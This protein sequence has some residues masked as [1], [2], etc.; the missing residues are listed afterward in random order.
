MSKAR[1]E[2]SPP[3]LSLSTYPL[4]VHSFLPIKPPLLKD[5]LSLS[6]HTNY[7]CIHFCQKTTTFDIFSL[8]LSQ[9]PLLVHSFLPIKPPLLIDFFSLST[10]LTVAFFFANKTTSFE[11]FSLSLSLYH[12]PLIF[13][14]KTHFSSLESFRERGLTNGFGHSSIYCISAINLKCNSKIY[15]LIVSGVASGLG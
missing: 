5:F 13:A 14:K 15:P 7:W 10:L 6:L 2:K 11:R 9:Y 12:L 3:L 8:S 1:P 4:L